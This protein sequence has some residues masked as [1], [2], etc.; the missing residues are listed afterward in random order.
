[1]PEM[2]LFKGGLIHACRK[3]RVGLC[4]KSQLHYILNEH[5]TGGVP[6]YYITKCDSVSEGSFSS[7]WEYC[8][9]NTAYLSCLDIWVM[10]PD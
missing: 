7:L 10:E 4:G 6:R 9:S 1:M 8:L 3:L 5:K 2:P